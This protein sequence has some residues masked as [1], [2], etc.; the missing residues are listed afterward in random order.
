MR[1]NLCTKAGVGK[2]YL[3]FISNILHRL[4]SRI[5]VFTTVSNTIANKTWG[6]LLKRYISQRAWQCNWGYIFSSLYCRMGVL[7]QEDNLQ[8][9]NITRKWTRGTNQST[10]TSSYTHSIFDERAFP[11]GNLTPAVVP[12]HHQSQQL[13]LGHMPA[14]LDETP[15]ADLFICKWTIRLYLPVYLFTL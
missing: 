14:F 13:C 10:C 11:L 7:F 3:Y 12:N 15:E 1:S 9:Q 8:S 5:Y 6:M 4:G 2:S